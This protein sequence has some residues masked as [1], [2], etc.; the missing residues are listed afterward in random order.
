M[1]SVTLGVVGLGNWGKNIVRSFARTQHTT[2]QYLCDT[3][4]RL[5][6][7][8]R[9]MYPQA[10]TTAKFSDLLDD[11]GLDAIAL[12]TP[13][14]THAELAQLAL[15]AGKHVFIEKPMTLSTADAE[16]L[17]ATADAMQR[18]LMVG[19]LL[20]YHPAVNWMKQYLDAG[21]LGAPLYLYTQR[22][23]LG[24]VRADENALW[25]LAPHDIS[26]I[27]YLFGSEPDWVA[28]HGECYLQTG[29]EDVVFTY[30]HFPDG[31][32]AQIHV[33][34]LDP[35]K[36]RRMVLVGTQT[37][38]VFDDMQPMELIRVYNKGAVVPE[39]GEITP[40][41]VR[42]GD[43]L[44]PHF[45]T[46]EPLQLEC[47]HFID[48][49]RTGTTPRSDGQDGLRVVRVLTAAYQ[50]LRNQG[51]PVKVEQHGTSALLPS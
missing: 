6:A 46:T 50:S 11:S 44:I 35:H 18:Q 20:E 1:E 27:L 47:Q 31:R 14:P 39:A 30:L 15:A 17:C 10:I 33:S 4:P 48:A 49:I 32:S 23:N 37:M 36:E 28:A 5:L 43:V 16:M 29:V 12:A 41:T 51:Q 34:W 21:E 8:Q 9:A 3:S 13:A 38:V 19:H 2:L 22:L 42:H 25:S 26:V 40:V 7:A 24:T 45:P